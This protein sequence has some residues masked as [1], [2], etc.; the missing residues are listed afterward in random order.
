M[1]NKFDN[2][3]LGHFK[4]YPM[5]PD[6]SNLASLFIADKFLCKLITNF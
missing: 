1:N 3:V 2:N 4:C 5:E 6:N